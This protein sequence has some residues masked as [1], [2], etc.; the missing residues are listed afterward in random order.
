MN[1]Y[2]LMSEIDRTIE[3]DQLLAIFDYLADGLASDVL[4]ERKIVKMKEAVESL[5]ERLETMK[6]NA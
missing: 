3:D 2:S 6:E 5:I 4:M 1:R